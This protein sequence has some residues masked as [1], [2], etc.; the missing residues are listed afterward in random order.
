MT[1]PDPLYYDVTRRGRGRRKGLLPSGAMDLRYATVRMYVTFVRF[2]YV[3]MLAHTNI[4][5]K[6]KAT[7]R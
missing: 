2:Y 6:R 1:S 5:L 3:T 7:V 4:N